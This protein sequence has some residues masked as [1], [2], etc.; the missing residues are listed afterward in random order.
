MIGLKQLSRECGLSTSTVSNVLSSRG[1]H[2][3]ATRERVFAMAKQYGYTPSRL[4]SSL[5]GKTSST[6]AV[7]ATDITHPYY[8]EVLDSVARAL[9]K[10]GLEPMVGIAPWDN[11]E[12]AGKLYK[13]FLSWRP[14]GFLLI[15]FGEVIPGL[16]A[17]HVEQVQK[18][19]VLITINRAVWKECPAVYPD[20]RR[21][22][23]LVVDHLTALNHRR[24]GF[25][26][27]SSRPECYRTRLLNDV[28]TSRG[29]ALRTDDI[30]SRPLPEEIGEDAAGLWFDLGKE[31]AARTDR[32]T[33]LISR[34]EPLANWFLG[35][36]LSAGGRVPSDLSIITH[37]NSRNA[38]MAS[39]PLTA[40][41]VPTG[42]LAEQTIELLQE[43]FSR[44]E[45]G[46]AF[47]KQVQLEPELRV[48]M[49]TGPAR[50]P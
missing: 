33:A 7:L 47:Q 15:T 6:V 25:L 21:S 31:F 46:E 9:L 27:L 50:C 22:M 16:T 10:I 8:A 49:S 26:N 45:A 14:R 40:V 39:V 19:A 17:E 38:G 41:G 20:N 5:C 34:S 44:R 30:L 36:F 18:N 2:S 13:S 28:L 24:I 1:R 35:G 4:A 3:Q 32:P 43:A 12:E 23:E 42:R 48:R 11:P 29:L 37:N